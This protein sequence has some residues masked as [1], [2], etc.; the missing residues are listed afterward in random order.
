MGAQVTRPCWPD[1]LL[2]GKSWLP[3]HAAGRAS[4]SAPMEIST[5]RTAYCPVR[6][7]K[8]EPC[9]SAHILKSA[10][11]LSFLQVIRATKISKNVTE[12]G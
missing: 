3:L 4:A 8:P 5:K 7:L 1:W 10:G 6:L 9:D 12:V 2:R 11:A